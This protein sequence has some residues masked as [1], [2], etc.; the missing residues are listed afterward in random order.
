MKSTKELKLFSKI[1]LNKQPTGIKTI[2]TIQ[3]KTQ[4]KLQKMMKKM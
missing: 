3:L 4:K 1:K 2:I